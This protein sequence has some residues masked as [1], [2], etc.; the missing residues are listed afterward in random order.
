MDDHAQLG[1]EDGQ[2]DNPFSAAARLVVSGDDLVRVE[3]TLTSHYGMILLGRLRVRWDVQFVVEFE[4][5]ADAA[6]VA[7]AL[8]SQGYTVRCSSGADLVRVRSALWEAM[9]SLLDNYREREVPN[10]C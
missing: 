6:L 9:T 1:C 7:V 10:G 4:E 3:Y 5:V 8:L 2:E